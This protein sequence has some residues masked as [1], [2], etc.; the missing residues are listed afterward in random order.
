MSAPAPLLL[1]APTPRQAPTGGCQTDARPEPP[2]AAPSPAPPPPPGPG[3][4]HPAARTRSVAAHPPPLRL[5]RRAGTD[6]RGLGACVVACGRAR[7]GGD[8]VSFFL[9]A[10][11]PLCLPPFFPPSQPPSLPVER[12]TDSSSCFHSPRSGRAGSASKAKHRHQIGCGS[13][14][15]LAAP[16]G[17][18]GRGG[19]GAAA[20]RTSRGAEG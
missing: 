7:S 11:L 19:A 9:S 4:A 3:G 1:A 10:S 20:E 15:P 8:R 14:P 18:P 16:G 17:R 5:A 12:S 13:A 6:G 2:P